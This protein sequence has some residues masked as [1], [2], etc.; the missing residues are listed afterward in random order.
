MGLFSGLKNI[1]KSVTGGDLLGLAGSFLGSKA[2]SDANSANVAMNKEFA[3]NGIRWKVADAQAAGVSPLFALGA[4]TIQPSAM[5]M[6]D[7]GVSDMFK[8]AGS[9]IDRAVQAQTTPA[10]RLNERLLN[11]QIEGQEVENAM[12]R[13]QLMRMNN[14][15]LPPALP[16]SAGDTYDAWA[17]AKNADGT[18]YSLTPSA[19]WAM[20]NQNL[21]TGFFP[22]AAHVLKYQIL[23]RFGIDRFMPDIPGYTRRG[24]DYYK[25]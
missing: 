7:T 1:V 23:P 20:A 14:P 25:Q 4:P 19:D 13:S 18:S 12:K 11:A 5:I 6:P 2:T 15:A 9:A 16:K 24:S 22:E 8:Q 3:Q 10:E 21:L 17:M